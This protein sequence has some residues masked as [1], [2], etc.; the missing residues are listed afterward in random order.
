MPAERF[1]IVVVVPVPDSAPGLIVQL[2]LDGKP[3]NSILPVDTVQLGWVSA[4]AIGAVGAPG[5]AVI[6]ISPDAAEVQPP[7]LVTV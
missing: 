2:P 3:L 7:A 1:R 5:A 6:T 4:M